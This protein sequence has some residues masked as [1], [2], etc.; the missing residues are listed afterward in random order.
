M[1]KR[2]KQKGSVFLLLSSRAKS[3]L[4]RG[5]TK[6]QSPATA[7][8]SVA[9]RRLGPKSFTVRDWSEDLAVLQ[10]GSEETTAEIAPRVFSLVSAKYADLIAERANRLSG[11]LQFQSNHLDLLVSGGFVECGGETLAYSWRLTE[12]L[13]RWYVAIPWGGIAAAPAAEAIMRMASQPWAER[14]SEW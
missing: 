1:R 5:Q 9:P 3:F 8:V 13:Y 7:P 11:A 2:S 10:A 4:S 14:R 12:A 6:S